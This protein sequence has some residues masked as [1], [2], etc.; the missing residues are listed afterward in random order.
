MKNSYFLKYII[1]IGL[2]I[3]VPSYAAVHYVTTN[4]DS[5]AGSLRDKVSKAQHGDTIIIKKNIGEIILGKDQITIE[6][7][8]TIKGEKNANA[9]IS[10]NRKTRIFGIPIDNTTVTLEN[11]TLKNAQTTASS[12]YQKP[13]INNVDGNGGAICSNGNLH[14]SHCKFLNNAT[15]DAHGGAIYSNKL[16]TVKHSVF[17]NNNAKGY[18]HSGGAISLN[19]PKET[20]NEISH[21]SFIKNSAKSDGGA[22]SASKNTIMK[23][24]TVKNNT[25]NNGGGISGGKLV[26]NSLITHN[27]AQGDF[28]DGGG[29]H[30]ID[31]VDLSTISENYTKGTFSSG[32]GLANISWLKNSIV[33]K[34]YTN[35][36]GGG[37]KYAWNIVNSLI[38]GNYTTG[39]GYSGGGV[40]SAERIVNSVIKDNYTRGTNA[41]GGGI[42]D[43]KWLVNSTVINNE[44]T[45]NSS[46]A[47]GVYSGIDSKIHNSTIINNRSKYAGGGGIWA[48]SY[49]NIS[50]SIISGNTQNGVAND[51]QAKEQKYVGATYS[52]IRS[53]GKSACGITATGK[54]HNIVAVDP[55][56]TKLADNGCS[57]KIGHSSNR[58]CLHSIAPQTNSP[59][60][61]KG[62]ANGHVSDQRGPGYRRVGKGKADIGAFE[63]QDPHNKPQFFF[64]DGF[65]G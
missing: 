42:Y 26:S 56:L 62:T 19:S 22:I 8:L 44:V 37:T 9:T 59:V 50:S 65:E 11:L 18:G 40:H 51:C 16:L 5:G 4:S 46:V 10:G 35:G 28:S 30:N 43:T 2:A 29:L 52:L 49:L 47:G 39:D 57:Y 24:L 34:N 32:G 14:I 36:N 45:G 64:I 31:I 23:Y 53:T 33:S 60:V 13:C 61:N 25:A 12:D 17:E 63:I 6:K 3:A 7:S 1:G 54:N 20:A 41:H 38:A 55:K 27:S 48:P 21:S 15:T 58:Q